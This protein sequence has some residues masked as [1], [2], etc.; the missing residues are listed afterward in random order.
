MVYIIYY[1]IKLLLYILIVGAVGALFWDYM[2]DF[3]HTGLQDITEIISTAKLSSMPII[4]G[5]VK[6]KQ[7][8]K[9]LPSESNTDF[10]AVRE[11]GLS[12]IEDIKSN[13]SK[14]KQYALFSTNKDNVDLIAN[15]DIS[16]AD[17]VLLDSATTSDI[18][19]DSASSTTTVKVLRSLRELL[20]STDQKLA[21][22]EELLE[23]EGLL[24]AIKNRVRSEVLQAVPFREECRCAAGSE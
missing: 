15:K 2:P 7:G 20:I 11:K 5:L 4:R 9:E 6:S 16:G 17:E 1:M 19:K 23:K 8:G 14:I 10:T 21:Q 18:I 22:L 24:S 3:F 13:I 12:L